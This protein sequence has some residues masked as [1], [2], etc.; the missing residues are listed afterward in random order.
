MSDNFWQKINYLCGILPLGALFGLIVF[1]TGIE[2]K[3]LDLWLHLAMGKFI[4][5]NHYVPSTD[6]LSCTLQGAP[7]I[8][9]EW[10]FQ[11]IVYNIHTAFGPDG[12]IKMQTVVVTATMLLLLFLAYHK[13]RQ[14]LTVFSLLMVF[15]VYQQRFTIRP[16]IYSL[17]FFTLY[18]FILSLHIDKRWAIFSLFIVQV[19]WV[20]MHGFFFFGPVFILIGLVSEWIKRSIPLP[21]A[22][23]EAGRLTD[24]EYGRMKMAFII[25]ILASFI[26]PLTF[27]G[28]WYPIATF[29]SLSGENKVF[30]D[31]IQELQRPITADTV[32]DQ[33]RFIYYKVLI[34]FSFISFV[35][36]RRKMDIS[37]FF[38]WIVFLMFSL[39][40]SRNTSFFAFAAYLVIITNALQISL[41]DIVPLRFTGKKFQYLTEIALKLAI[42][43]WIVTYCQDIAVRGYYDFDKYERKSEFGGITQRVYPDKAT[44]FLIEHNI[45]GN[46]FNDFNSG[47]YLLGRTFPDIK[48]FIDGRTEVYGGAFFN[49]YRKIWD[50]GNA[51]A[52]YKAADKYNLT[53]AL[54]NSTTQHI[55]EGILK[56][57]YQHKEWKVVYFDYDAVIFLKDVPQNR[58]IIEKFSIDLT[59]WQ[60][61]KLDLLRVGLEKVVPYQSYYRAFTLETVGLDEQAI[62][63]AKEAIRVTPGY[64]DPYDLIGKIYAKRGDYQSAFEHFRI[65]ALATPRKKNVRY[66]LALAYFDLGKYEEAIKQ[67]HAIIGLWPQD[68]KGYF[69]LSKTLSASKQYEKAINV[70]KKARQMQPD[71]IRDILGIGDIIYQQGEYEHAREVYAIALESNKEVNKVQMKIAEAENMT[72]GITNSLEKE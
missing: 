59:Q 61:K 21:Y 62:G 51:E 42:L 60:P 31:F 32:L 6:V 4:T 17:L 69:L 30:F 10:L 44:D 65:A 40:A 35:F 36:N 34:F 5:L 46:F 39:K 27:K 49:N 38:L 70:L 14:L 71:H 18:I 3:D 2:I 23:N 24:E 66:N 29:F 41:G 64:G 63:E 16:D 72:A 20:N 12:L 19:L 45:K 57:L 26:N 52:F 55:P 25:V 11:V 22:W 7:W 56:H 68:A 13:D 48:V 33:G 50:N 67:Y 8:N 43:I 47:A 1:V 15:L 9:H 28:A 54:L 53:G 58:D 37:A